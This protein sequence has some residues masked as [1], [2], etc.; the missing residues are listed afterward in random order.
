MSS[1][2]KFFLGLVVLSLICSNGFAASKTWTIPEILSERH[3]DVAD[4]K[5]PHY[6]H[7]GVF[8]PCVCARDVTKKVQYRPSV[9]E[10]KGRAALI[11]SGKYLNAYSLVVRDNANK[12]RWPPSGINGCS[13]YERDTLGLNKCSAFKVQKVI[14][15]ENSKA[16]AEVHCLGSSGYGTLFRRVQR[17]T[18]KLADIPGST[19]DPLVRLCLVG[20][21]EP[22]N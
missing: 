17:I 22:L 10:C 19:N 16:D 20:P 21:T 5:K 7:G 14:P 8:K 18:I 12:D 11:V 4:V 13:Q 1:A 3:L 6:C 15:V 9:K 2:I